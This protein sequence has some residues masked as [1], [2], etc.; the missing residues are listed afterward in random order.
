MAK[1]SRRPETKSAEGSIPAEVSDRMVR[2][3]VW[4]AGVPSILGVSAFIANYYL[5]VNKILILPTWVTLVETLALF[6]FGFV[7]ISY[8]VLSAS[9]E[10]EQTGSWLGWQEFRVNLGILTQQWRE[11]K[12]EKRK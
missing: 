4:L 12:Q 10:P 1:Q 3:V 2:R 11:Q 6:G 5:L 9:W 8:G 7:G